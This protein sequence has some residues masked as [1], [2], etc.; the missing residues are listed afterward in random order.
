MEQAMKLSE[1]EKIA[2]DQRADLLAADESLPRE[3][4]S[5]L[6]DVPSHALIVRQ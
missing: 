2:S 5:R 3:M 6:P 1:I 4:L